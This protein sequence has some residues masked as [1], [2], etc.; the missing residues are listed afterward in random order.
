MALEKPSETQPFCTVPPWHVPRTPGSCAEM[1]LHPSGGDGLW[2]T[3]GLPLHTS[4]F[5]LRWNCEDT[6]GPGGP[7]ECQFQNKKRMNQ[8]VTLGKNT[9]H[10]IHFSE[11]EPHFGSPPAPQGHVTGGHCYWDTSAVRQGLPCRDLWGVSLLCSWGESHEARLSALT[12]G[13][14]SAPPASSRG[15]TQARLRFGLGTRRPG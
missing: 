12:G 11:E 3:R 14:R 5:L 8:R 13:V 1:S 6:G 9:T 7:A 10:K 2:G 4:P 15:V